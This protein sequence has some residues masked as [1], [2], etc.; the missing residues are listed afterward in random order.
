M[1]L[2]TFITYLTQ[3]IPD[4]NFRNVR[5]YGLFSNRNKGK[6][7]DIARKILGRSKKKVNQMNFRERIKD[8]TGTDPLICNKCN[9]EMELIFYCFDFNRKAIKKFKLKKN[10]RIPNKQFSL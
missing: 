4:K 3:H 5:G 6:L 7:L 2:F 1:R 9:C 8:L 10:E